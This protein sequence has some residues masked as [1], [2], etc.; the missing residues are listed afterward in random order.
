MFD[1][2]NRRSSKQPC[3][4]SLTV[5]WQPPLFCVMLALAVEDS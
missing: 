1:D 4:C 3:S 5:F 2:L